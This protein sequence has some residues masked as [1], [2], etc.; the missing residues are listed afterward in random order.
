M[1][2]AHFKFASATVNTRVIKQSII[3]YLFSRDLNERGGLNNQ[4]S[5]ESL[6]QNVETRPHG[7]TIRDK[8]FARHLL[9]LGQSTVRTLKQDP[10]I[11]CWLLLR[12]LPK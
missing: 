2:K 7:A 11:A 10:N 8:R 6:C 1:E 5:T 4:Q 12:H 9:C 3:P